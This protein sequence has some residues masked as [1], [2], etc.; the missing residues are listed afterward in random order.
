MDNIFLDDTDLF[1]PHKSINKRVA[2]LNV[3]FDNVSVWF[4]SNKLSLN[5]VETIWSLPHPLCQKYFF[6][7][8]LPSLVI[9]NIPINGENVKKFLEVYL[10][11]ICPGNIALI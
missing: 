11:K 2:S 9:E 4:K 8:T 7:K 1:I 5:L 10:P 6:T 3:E